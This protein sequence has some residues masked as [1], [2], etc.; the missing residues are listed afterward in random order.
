MPSNIQTDVTLTAK[1]KGLD[2]ALQKT[3][4]VNRAGL[5]GMRKQAAA[6]QAA[7]KEVQ[8]YED[9]LKPIIQQQKELA[10]QLADTKRGTDEYKKLQ[11]SL[12]AV[13]L[14]YRDLSQAIDSIQRA[15]EGAAASQRQLMK[16][17]QDY[18]KQTE[19]DRRQA[20]T[21]REKRKQA[22]V[23]GF[24]QAMPIPSAFVD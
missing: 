24:A 9:R 5:E 7:Q 2:A 19:A 14:E 10:T 21:E 18:Q 4:G 20:E 1:T 23:Q 22:F 8:K 15:N 12:Q 3:M 16:A 11:K 17:E 6:F 13:K